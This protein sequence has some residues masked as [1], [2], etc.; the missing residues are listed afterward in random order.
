MA[1]KTLKGAKHNGLI[2]LPR[3]CREPISQAAL[4]WTL[5]NPERVLRRDLV[6]RAAARR[7]VPLSLRAR[8]LEAR[9]LAILQEYDRQIRGKLLLAPL[10]GMPRLLLRKASAVHDVLR[11]RMYF[12]D[13]G[14]EKEAMRLYAKL[15]KKASACASCSA[16]CAGACP[17][18]VSIQERM[19]TAH[20]L[21][22]LV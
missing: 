11:H 9:D 13:Y 18:G 16:P 21:L 14:W 22:T 10:R 6:L 8:R 1:M 4:K 17:A 20:D 2:G 15:E 3:A 12:E 7:R 5:S 19:S